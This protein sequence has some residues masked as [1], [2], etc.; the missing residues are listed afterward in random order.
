MTDVVWDAS[1]QAAVADAIA[2]AITPPA[3]ELSPEQAA[4]CDL[5]ERWWYDPERPQVFVIAGYAGTGKS[6]TVASAVDRL[7]IRSR[8]MYI[9]PTGKAALV[10]N[11]KGL[12]ASTLHSAIYRPRT[13]KGQVVGYDLREELVGDPRLIVLDECSMVGS[14]VLRDLLSFKVPVLALGDP[15]QLPPVKATDSG[16]LA[17]PTVF[18]QQIHR[19]A[20]GNPIL[21]ASFLARTG[22]P[23]PHGHWGAGG[24]LRVINMGE[25]FR[26]EDLFA[27]DQILCCTNKNR[28]WLND[29]A[30]ERLGRKSQWPEVGDRVICTK[31]SRD[32]CAA[33]D[34]E[35]APLVNG[36]LGVVVDVTPPASNSRSFVMSVALENDPTAI[37]VDMKVDADAFFSVPPK[38]PNPAYNWLTHWEFGYAITVH[39]SQG[40]EWDKVMLV[41]DLFG[42]DLNRR[43]LLYTGITRA[44]KALT[45]AQ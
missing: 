16:L 45:L 26:T 18:L 12:P 39:K 7:N 37:F 3:L 36:L 20:E 1:D 27:Y 22:S 23:V 13:E 19:Q 34:S 8:T 17:A 24:E 11:R 14:E 10:L 31:N 30:R 21:W 33:G 32:H 40:S 4:A 38:M 6:T 43:Q 2:Q 41:A 28:K 15:G 25:A 9:A 42:D 5:L 44:A 35:I 29:K